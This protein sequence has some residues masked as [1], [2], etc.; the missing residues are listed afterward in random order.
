[1][2]FTF[3][4]PNIS[5]AQ[6]LWSGNTLICEGLTG[7]I[8][9]VTPAGDIV[10]EYISPHWTARPHYGRINWV[11]RAHRYAADSAQIGNRI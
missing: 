5:G 4:S 6:R 3:F 8:F 2:L 10:W 11:F 1:V 9:E 7:R